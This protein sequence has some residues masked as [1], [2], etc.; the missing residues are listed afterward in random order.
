MSE[1]K[2]KLL[3]K[4]PTEDKTGVETK[5]LGVGPG[6]TPRK[7]RELFKIPD[8]LIAFCRGRNPPN[9]DEEEDLYKEMP[10]NAVLEFLPLS[11]VA[12][13]ATPLF[14]SIIKQIKNPDI[15]IYENDQEKTLNSEIEFINTL[16]EELAEMGWEEISNG[17]RGYID[18]PS[19]KLPAILERRYG[20]VF[21]LYVYNP[22]QKILSCPRGPCF[23][24]YR[25]E[26]RRVNFGI[27]NQPA[28]SLIRETEYV[29]KK[30]G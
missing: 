29:L 1:E 6:T 13:E 16:S 30:W 23:M 14:I 27:K 7:L 25:D 8:G 15:I 10:E 2:K 12:E 21:E 3:I 4:K 19:F 18:G 17:F 24:S 28:L 11:P 9:I 5:A 20:A 26:W 22:P